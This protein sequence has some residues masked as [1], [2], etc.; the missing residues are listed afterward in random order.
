MNRKTIWQEKQNKVSLIVTDICKLLDDD[1][2]ISGNELYE[3]LLRR[4]VFKWF[5]CRRQLIKLKY[6]WRDR[7]TASIEAQKL[8]K[9]RQ[10]LVWYWR[11]YRKA[12]E[13]CRAEVREICHS[14]RWQ[15]QDNDR[16]AARWMKEYEEES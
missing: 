16:R 7:I 8:F 10:E 13:E 1:E 9:D 6:I 11:G 2:W 12:L 5:A 4:G 14:D 15:V 3:I